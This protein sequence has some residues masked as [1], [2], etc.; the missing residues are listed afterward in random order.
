MFTTTFP[1]HMSEEDMV[2]FAEGIQSCVA[3]TG[4][5]EALAR[6]IVAKGGIIL[7][8]ST[9]PFIYQGFSDKQHVV[10]LLPTETCCCSDSD[11]TQRSVLAIGGSVPIKLRTKHLGAK[12]SG[13]KCA[14]KE[15]VQ[16][17]TKH[18]EEPSTIDQQVNKLW[19]MSSDG[20]TG[21]PQVPCS[22]TSLEQ[23]SCLIGA[24]NVANYHWILLNV[25]RRT[26]FAIFLDPTGSPNAESLLV[27]LLVPLMQSLLVPLMQRAYWFP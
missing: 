20:V 12:R 1:Y 3:E 2:S 13:H 6:M 22:L 8:P 11:S 23:H 5:S 9:Q 4:A 26:P 14:S 19:A 18:Q 10:T 15:H 17:P 25:H 24:C 21:Q 7:V 16:M 27:P